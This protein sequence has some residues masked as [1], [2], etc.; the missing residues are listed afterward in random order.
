MRCRTIFLL[1]VMM[2]TFVVIS[3][4]YPFTLRVRAAG[5]IT[6]T[7]NTVM[8]IVNETKIVEGDIVIRGN[9]TL[10]VYNSTLTLSMVRN[11]DYEIR[12]ENALNGY[13]RLI[14][15]DSNISSVNNKNFKI[16]V[17]DGFV[18]FSSVKTVD[19]FSKQFSFQY[20]YYDFLV[21]GNSNV[22]L[23]KSPLRKISAFDSSVVNISYCNVKGLYS[24]GRAEIYCSK[25]SMLND[26]H[27]EDESFIFISS[28]HGT[29]SLT[30]EA[31]IYVKGNSTVYISSTSITIGTSP[32]AKIEVFDNGNLT[33]VD[34]S[35]STQ[36][37]DVQIKT[38]GNSVLSLKDVVARQCVLSFYDNS[39][40]EVFGG[41]SLSGVRVYVY[42]NSQLK[43]GSHSL[44]DWLLQAE[45]SSFVSINESNVTLLRG[46]DSSNISVYNS[47]IGV[48]QIRDFCNAVFVGSTIRQVS[49][50]F[51][52]VNFSLSS[53][54]D[55]FFAYKDFDIPGVLFNFV[56]NNSEI[57][58][59]WSIM[60][61]GLSNVTVLDSSLWFI[62]V[63]GDS[64]VEV[65]NSTVYSVPSVSGSSRIHFVS[66]LTVNVVDGFG[67]PVQGANV[68]LSCDD[69]VLARGFSDENG[70][71]SFVLERWFNA[72]GVFP[73]SP[74]N[75]TVSYED[76]HM[77]KLV[78]LEYEEWMLD[79]FVSS[80]ALPL[81]F[82]YWLLVY[83]GVGVAVCV[84]IAL[85]FLVVKKRRKKIDF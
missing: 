39:T 70:M 40:I 64:Y 4:V 71:V 81:P 38:Y 57:E 25:V 1:M 55:G 79:S 44:V 84:V 26:V 43:I 10:Y 29:N 14:I 37:R 73:S 54:S 45:D 61:H 75:V 67:N 62:G 6:L 33:I 2:V 17:Y 56:L 68:T 51:I 7:G 80:V 66:Y 42:G 77:S 50:E 46:I 3:D 35:I 28:P 30:K 47:V 12:L 22:S 15:V 82:W 5:G 52:S 16:N 60:V 72:S 24:Y 13:P 11:Y 48:F 59:G 78:D 20:S 69:V 41:S 21:Y 8:E 19:D 9:A 23:S 53:I 58:T 36:Y 83:L 32:Y 76:S 27:A 65:L 34:S 63:S 74:F 31:D 85:V 18:N 49:L